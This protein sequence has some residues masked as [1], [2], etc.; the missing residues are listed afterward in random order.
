MSEHLVAVTGEK[1]TLKN[2]FS[3]KSGA[4]ELRSVS[5]IFVA[6]LAYIC[7]RS[8]VNGCDFLDR[9]LNPIAGKNTNLVRESVLASVFFKGNTH[10]RQS[11]RELRTA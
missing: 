3:G 6:R 9:P 5:V 11:L 1:L 2:V 7:E 4:Y 10:C 8:G